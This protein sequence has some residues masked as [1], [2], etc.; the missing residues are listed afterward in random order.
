MNILNLLSGIK[1][2]KNELKN[3]IIYMKYKLSIIN[4]VS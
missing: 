3:S 4:L 2:K 1:K